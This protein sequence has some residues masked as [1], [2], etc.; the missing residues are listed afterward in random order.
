MKPKYQV[1]GCGKKLTGKF[2]FDIYYDCEVVARDIET[3][4]NIFPA[5]MKWLEEEQ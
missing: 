1:N 4:D 3:R 2:W 5:L